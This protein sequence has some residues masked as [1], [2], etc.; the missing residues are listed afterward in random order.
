[1]FLSEN[2]C[3]IIS[4]LLNVNVL[5]PN[6]WSFLVTVSCALETICSIYIRSNW[7]RV[8]IFMCIFFKSSIFLL[9]FCLLVQLLRVLTSASL[10]VDLFPFQFCLFLICVFWSFVFGY[11]HIEDWYIF[12]TNWSLSFNTRCPF[13]YLVLILVLKSTS[14]DIHKPLQLSIHC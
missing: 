7:L 3:C 2:I 5:W 6:M 1:M 4:V 14:S 9:T 12:P 8:V 11:V 10:F 13:L